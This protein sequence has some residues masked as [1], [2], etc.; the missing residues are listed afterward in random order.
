MGSAPETL[1]VFSAVVET[2]LNDGVLT[3][4]E[5]RL[6]ITIGRELELDDGDPVMI[7]NAVLK[8]E[9]ITGGRKLTRNERV[10]VYRKSWRTVNFNDDESIDEA[11]V[12]KRLREVLDFSK[13]EAEELVKPLLSSSEIPVEDASSISSRFRKMFRR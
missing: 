13:E 5:K 9:I 7:Y 10:Q 2:V 4:E 1:S 3:Q 11:A 8:G 12:M 6:I